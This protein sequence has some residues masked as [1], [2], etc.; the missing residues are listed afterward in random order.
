MVAIRDI[1]RVMMFETYILYFSTF[2]C[3]SL[4][5]RLFYQKN[6]SL[7]LFFLLIVFISNILLI[8]IDF[9]FIKEFSLNFKVINC[10]RWILKKLY[11][12]LIIMWTDQ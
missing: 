7:I 10:K 8:V 3:V 12:K 11:I 5:T 9:F 1:I 4:A 2:K 6:T